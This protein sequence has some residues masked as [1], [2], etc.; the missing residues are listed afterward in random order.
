MLV[1][2]RMIRAYGDLCEQDSKTG[3]TPLSDEAK[4]RIKKRLHQQKGTEE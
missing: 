2:R 4:A 3:I 1:L